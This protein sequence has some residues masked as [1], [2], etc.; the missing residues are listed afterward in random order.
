MCKYFKKIKKQIKKEFLNLKKLDH[1]NIVK[2]YELYIDKTNG[3]I[4]TVMELIKGQE[5]FETI[6]KSGYYSEK[7]AKIIFQQIIE[8]IQYMHSK[9]ICHRDLKLNNILCDEG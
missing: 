6:R 1:Q 3:C 5:I 2:M 7:T 8:A 4:Y 9:S